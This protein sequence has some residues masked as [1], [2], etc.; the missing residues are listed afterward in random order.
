MSAAC[1]GTA[2]VKGD[3]AGK[4]RGIGVAAELFRAASLAGEQCMHWD[5]TCVI[6]M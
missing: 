3:A 1:I 2:Y 5:W 6:S 4:C